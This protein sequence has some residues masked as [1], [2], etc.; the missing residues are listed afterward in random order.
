MNAVVAVT[1]K[2]QRAS[3]SKH[4][5]SKEFSKEL[6]SRTKKTKWRSNVEKKNGYCSWCIWVESRQSRTK[7]RWRSSAVS[8]HVSRSRSWRN[9]NGKC[10]KT[11]KEEQWP[12]SAPQ[13]HEVVLDTTEGKV[14]LLHKAKNL[15]LKQEGRCTG[16]VF[17]HRD[18]TPGQREARKPLL[19]ELK[20]SKANGE[21]NLTIMDARSA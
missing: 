20:Q 6:C 13:T 9:Q 21:S 15:R 17:I 5:Q 11:K 1:Q 14:Q 4:R 10:S 16:R 18:L 8:S 7:G 2:N 12:S 3:R 19:A